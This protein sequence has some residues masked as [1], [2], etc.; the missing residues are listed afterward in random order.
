M[1]LLPLGMFGP[2]CF[3][4]H[5]KKAAREQVL[6]LVL[7]FRTSE[8]YSKDYGVVLSSTYSVHRMYFFMQWIL[9]RWISKFA[10]MKSLLGVSVLP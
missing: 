6:K 7:E 3:C 8:T 4:F 9:S 5:I 2:L 1:Q 10:E